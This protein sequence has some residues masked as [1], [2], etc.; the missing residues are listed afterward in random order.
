MREK[1]PPTVDDLLGWLRESAN[2]KGE[3]YGVKRFYENWPVI[4]DRNR[5]NLRA[6][7]LAELERRGL[8][9]RIGG[10]WVQVDRLTERRSFSDAVAKAGERLFLDG[11]WKFEG[12][13]H[14][15]AWKVKTYTVITDGQTYARCNCAHGTHGV[16]VG[17]ANCKH[18]VCVLHAMRGDGE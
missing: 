10:G 17:P 12:G 8:V 14:N 13:Y 2:P 1:E 18:V 11:E 4:G 15:D 9:R 6:E 5:R 3:V 7:H 16:I